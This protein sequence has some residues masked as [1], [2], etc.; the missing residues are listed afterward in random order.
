M[1]ELKL[2]GM[3][4]GE[5]LIVNLNHCALPFHVLKECEESPELPDIAE[6][7]RGLV[8]DLLFREELPNR[9][10]KACDPWEMRHEFFRLKRDSSALLEF[11]NKW[12]AWSGSQQQLPAEIWESQDTFRQALRGSGP[13]FGHPA[14]VLS[15]PNAR[16]EYPHFMLQASDCEQAIRSTI[17]FDLVRKIK[18]CL[19]ARPDCS[20]VFAIESRHKRK[21]CCQYCAHLESVRRQRREAKKAKGTPER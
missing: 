12:G 10:M 9:K 16:K 7:C 20:G 2:P 1:V 21:F 4:Q 19:C 17:T 3:K 8:V 13:W 15:Y 14:S 5:A 18:F 11:L 6:L